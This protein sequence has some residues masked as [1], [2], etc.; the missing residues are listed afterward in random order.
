[1]GASSLVVSIF[2]VLAVSPLI[3]VGYFWLGWNRMTGTCPNQSS[4]HGGSVSFSYST[5]LSNPGFTCTW[6]DGHQESKLWW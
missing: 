3:G 4:G 6:S 5:S 2:V 1:M